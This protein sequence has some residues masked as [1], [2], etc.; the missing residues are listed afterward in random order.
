[1]NDYILLFAVAGLGLILGSFLNAL[2]YRFNT[3]L[4]IARGRSRCMRCGHTLSV[5]D[6]VPVLSYLW[7]RGVCR[8]C[9][10]HISWQYPL[11]ELSASLLLLF[12]FITTPQPLLFVLYSAVWLTLLFTL[13][14]DLRHMMIPWASANTLI[15]LSLVLLFFHT[16]S[17][18]IPS[19]FA[20]LAGPL[21]AAPL[22]LVSLVSRGR[23]MGWGDGFLE[24]SLGWLLGLYGGV[25]AL[26]L[27]FWSGAIL[28]LLLMLFQYTGWKLGRKR[29]TMKSEVPF[30]PF[31]IFGAAAVYFFHVD[32]FH[33]ILLA[34]PQ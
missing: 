23:A 3:G 34:L 27:A 10:A 28:G 9:G 4:S 17:F 30:A 24:L 14:Y 5:L 18:A 26:L 16:G 21:C 12:V 1:M 31:L 32:P 11:V 7:L 13:V 15:G 22:F 2:I 8:Y 19:T 20:L 33:Y 6:L 25:A 29:L